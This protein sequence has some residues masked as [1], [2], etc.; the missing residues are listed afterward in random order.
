VSRGNGSARA[1]SP[2]AARLSCPLDPSFDSSLD[3]GLDP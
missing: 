1:E 3:S 2:D